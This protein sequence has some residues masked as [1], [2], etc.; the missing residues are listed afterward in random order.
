MFMKEGFW[1]KRVDVERA[2]VQS[3]ELSINLISQE[4]GIFIV[5][6]YKSEDRAVSN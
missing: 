2:A 5:Y 6:T 1:S 4:Y 3:T